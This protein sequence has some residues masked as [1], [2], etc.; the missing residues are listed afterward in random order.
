MTELKAYSTVISP[1]ECQTQDFLP[2]E[3]DS[4]KAPKSHRWKGGKKYQNREHIFAKRVVFTLD[5]MVAYSND[6]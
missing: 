2:R 1:S 4:E 3:E 6:L 5:G